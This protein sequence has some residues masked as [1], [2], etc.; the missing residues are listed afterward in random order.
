MNTTF[1]TTIKQTNNQNYIKHLNVETKQKNERFY[2][3]K[4][5]LYFDPFYQ[6]SNVSF[7]FDWFIH[8]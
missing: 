1:T 6:H 8:Y 7:N 5:L 2:L 4:K 3:N